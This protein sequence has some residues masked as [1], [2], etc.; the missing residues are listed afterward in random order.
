[1]D[2]SKT[3]LAL[4]DSYTIGEAVELKESF[5][6]QLVSTLNDKGFNYADPKVIAV[7]GW[8]SKNLIN[9][10]KSDHIQTTFDLVT[11]L[12]GVNNQYQGLPSEHFRKEFRI[13]LDLAI[14]FSAA[15]KESV[16]VLSIPDWSATPFGRNRDSETISS[17]VDLFN[18]ICRE[19]TELAGI[20]FID[21]TPISRKANT[22]PHLTAED[23]LH[24]SRKMY[25][26]WVALLASQIVQKAKN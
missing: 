7:T 16:Y 23:R 13:L 17:E 3:Y 14:A 5:P 19:E 26:E 21:I 20:A 1:M 25:A 9:G 11:L 12:I 10:I 6:F 8:T 18:K 24:P 15:G 2:K 22:D 4:G